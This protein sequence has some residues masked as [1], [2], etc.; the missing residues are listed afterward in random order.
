MESRDPL[1]TVECDPW[2]LS[3]IDLG[4][5]ASGKGSTRCSPA[6]RPHVGT[7]LRG[8]PGAA[9]R[10]NRVLLVHA[11]PSVPPTEVPLA[12]M[13]QWIVLKPVEVKA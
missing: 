1:R 9:A 8:I 11:G 6:G 3:E 12:C 7:G 5:S 10:K 13:T 4:A 2:V